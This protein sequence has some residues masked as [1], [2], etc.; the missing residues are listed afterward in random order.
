MRSD[1]QT[2]AGFRPVDSLGFTGIGNSNVFLT[3]PFRCAGDF[4][5]PE[6]RTAP[7]TSSAAGFEARMDPE[8]ALDVPSGE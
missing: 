4:S 3:L 2:L 8:E 5:S 1:A 7:R 6:E